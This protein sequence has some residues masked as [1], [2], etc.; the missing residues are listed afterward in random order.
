MPSGSHQA[1]GAGMCF[2][3]LLKL[4]HEVRAQVES[5]WQR[6][7][8]SNAALIAVMV[9]FASRPEPFVAARLVVFAFYTG[10]VLTSII[11]LTQAYRGLRILTFEITQC[12]NPSVSEAVLKWLTRSDYRAESWLRLSLPVVVW[13]LVAY[14]MILPLIF[15]R[16]TF[17][18]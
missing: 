15:G 12:P 18:H 6:L 4:T 9:F 16:T 7:I 14:L 10:T 11:N 17:L 13:I 8:N 2:E 1:A 5:E 3:D